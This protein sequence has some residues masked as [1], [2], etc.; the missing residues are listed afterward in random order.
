M[1]AKYTG[2]VFMDRMVMNFNVKK[3]GQILQV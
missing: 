3:S 1:S 2:K